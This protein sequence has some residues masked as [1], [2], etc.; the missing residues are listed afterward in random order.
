V[1]EG[2]RV[3]VGL[4]PELLVFDGSGAALPPVAAGR[5]VLVV[6]AHQD[7]AV[8]TGYLNAYR[9]L[10]ADL[11]VVTMAEEETRHAELASALRQVTR[12]QVPVIRTTLRPVPTEP[13]AGERVAFFGT[14]P[15]IAQRRI[16]TT[17]ADRHGAHVV[18]VSGALADRTRLREELAEVDAETFLVE[19]KAAAV[20]VVA[21]E[22]QRRGARIVLAANEVVPLPG[23][24]ALDDELER[25]AA[26]A[27][28]LE[29]AI[30]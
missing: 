29:E 30:A 7:V 10:I 19:L 16:A 14:A 12:P 2:A 25:V 23:E 6:G 22:A 5:R 8:A 3:A 27:V 15:A 24:P 13:V 28:A 17:L 18:H 26:E 1:L 4:D 21:A 11:V 9:A 20:D